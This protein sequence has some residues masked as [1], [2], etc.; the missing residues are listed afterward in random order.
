MARHREAFAEDKMAPAVATKEGTAT[1][2]GDARVHKPTQSRRRRVVPA[3][4]RDPSLPTD[5][6][7]VVKAV[8]GYIK[9]AGACNTSDAVMDVLSEKLRSWCD[10][11]IERA[12]EEGRKTVLDRDFT[13]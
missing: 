6:L 13:V 10:R 8:K 7:V 11:A 12:K 5:T 4:R 1:V 3:V 9:A 2:G